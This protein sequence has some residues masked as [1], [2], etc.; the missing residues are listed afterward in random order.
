MLLMNDVI[1]KMIFDL[2]KRP[3]TKVQNS[4]QPNR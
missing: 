3:N 2:E 1:Y 4:H